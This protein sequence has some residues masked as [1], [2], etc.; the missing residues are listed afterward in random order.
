MCQTAN[1][2][3]KSEGKVNTKT[4]WAFAC[5]PK[6]RGKLLH[7]LTVFNNLGKVILGNPYKMSL[8]K[9]KRCCS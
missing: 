9:I 5:C 4:V 2:P 6:I 3:F 7:F 1:D 8:S